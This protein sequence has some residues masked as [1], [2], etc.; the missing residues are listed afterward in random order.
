MGRVAYWRRAFWHARRGGLQQVRSYLH[1]SSPERD[2]A[3]LAGVRGAEGVWRGLGRRRRL[4]FRASAVAGSAPRRPELRVGIIMDDFSAAAFA[5]E[6]TVIAIDPR[7]WQAQLDQEELD[8]VVVESAWSGNGGLWRGK[9]TGPA[10]PGQELVQ[11]TAGCR[12][13][14]IP[15]VFWNKEDPPHYEDFLPAARLFDHVF[16]TDVNRVA[17][18][19]ADLGHERVSVLP[20]AAQPAIHN[21]VRPRHG[22]HAR[23]MAFA[24]MYFAHKYPD[25]RRQMEYLLGAAADA[26]AGTKDGFE[27]F[28]RQLGKEQQ[29]Q[30]PAALRKYVVG[31]LS[32]P[33]MLTAYKAYRIF[34]N[35]NSVTDSPSMCARRIFEITAAGTSVVSTPSVAISEFFPGG[36]ILTASTRQEAVDL[37]RALSANPEYS[38]RSVHRA[39]RLIWSAH[40]YTH[41]AAS[42]AAA[43][44]PGSAAPPPRPVISVLAASYRPHQLQHVIDGVAGQQGVDVQLVY[45]AHGFDIDAR[46]FRDQCR[47]AGLADAVLL[48]EPEGTSLG[49]CLNA[50]VHAADGDLATK[51]DDDDVYAPQYLGD[52]TH[53]RMYSG[54]EIVGKRAH[55]MH[56]AGPDATILRNAQL[57]HRFVSAVA[58]PT[59][60]A[61]TQ[62][63]RD[64]PFHPLR[65]GEDTRFLAD[66][67]DAGARIYSAD[68]FNYCQLRRRDVASHTW[69]ITSDQLMASSKIQFFGPPADHV[70]V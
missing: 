41:R 57:E 69:S 11:F 52:L 61:A 66:A 36:E 63:F 20:F 5:S 43:V 18:Y 3:E 32:Y 65:T 25:R 10:G 24:G 15:C 40:T 14:G 34:L 42:I 27:I 55:Y 6:W 29:Y 44:L 7:S 2:E 12:A 49:E 45:L 1:R 53:A 58:G 48:L 33:Q 35:V 17:A 56:L 13:A 60:F 39:Q 26:A 30:F 16:T 21:P 38:E 4:V 67:I 8:L 9:I 62:T 54:A 51:W 37:L 70:T 50:L 19:H 28:S 64:L 46:S 22:W 31:S 47:E 59:I 23:G 68:R